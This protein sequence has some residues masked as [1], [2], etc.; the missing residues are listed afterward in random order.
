MNAWVTDLLFLLTAAVVLFG[1]A[2]VAFSKNIVR[3]VFSLLLTLAG[4]AAVY[5]F[6][7]ADFMAVIQPRWM[8]S[9]AQW[10]VITWGSV[11]SLFP[12]RSMPW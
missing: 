3:C 11:S 5:V 2:V 4:V 7:F 8:P 10:K 1:A 12:K 9:W 6:L